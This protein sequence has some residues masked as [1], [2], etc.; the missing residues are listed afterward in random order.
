MVAS[1]QKAGPFVLGT[2]FGLQETADH[3]QP[4]RRCGQGLIRRAG[5]QREAPLQEGASYVKQTQHFR[6]AQRVTSPIRPRAG[7]R[8]NELRENNRRE[9]LG[10][11]AH[12]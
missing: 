5:E 7:I 8:A 3:P 6:L 1:R 4:E 12:P 10:C 9:R 11:P 2:R